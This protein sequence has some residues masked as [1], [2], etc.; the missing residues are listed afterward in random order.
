MV[1]KG[2]SAMPATCAV[3]FCGRRGA[4]LMLSVCLSVSGGVAEP[5]SMRWICEVHAPAMSDQMD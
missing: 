5:V 1:D 2:A 4:S 3:L